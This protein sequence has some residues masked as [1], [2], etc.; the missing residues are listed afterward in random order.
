MGLGRARK[1][2]GHL[3]H[4][5]NWLHHP[6][7]VSSKSCD[8]S[9]R[10]AP[11]C[12]G[13]HRGARKTREASFSTLTRQADH[14]TLS[15]NALRSRG[16]RSALWEADS[17]EVPCSGQGPRPGPRPLCSLYL[18]Q[19]R[20][21]QGLLSL[22]QGQGD[23]GDQLHRDVQQG[24]SHHGGLCHLLCQQGQEGQEVQHFPGRGE[25]GLSDSNEW[26][27]TTEA[28]VR[29]AVLLTVSLSPLPPK[30]YS[31]LLRYSQRG[32]GGQLGQQ[33]QGSQ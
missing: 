17:G 22:Q 24:Q 31:L 3:A 7:P 25:E 32:R 12:G 26:W 27:S 10:G 15:S 14:T 28:S 23:Q 33:H 30:Q 8:S 29:P 21:H 2:P 1:P 9:S 6:H 5:S 16:T 11:R 4:Q 13:T 19:V 20:Q 18:Q